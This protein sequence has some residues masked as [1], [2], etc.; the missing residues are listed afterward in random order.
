[1]QKRKVIAPWRKVIA[2]EKG[3]R[4]MQLKPTSDLRKPSRRDFALSAAAALACPSALYAHPFAGLPTSGTAT[5]TRFSF[6]LWALAKQLPFDRCLEVV[7]AAGYQGVELTGEFQ[8]WSPAETT[9]ILNHMHDLGLV[10][11]SMSG[12]RAGFAVPEETQAFL[13]QFAQHLRYAQQLSCP[14]VILLSGKRMAG[15]TPDVQRTTAIENL[16]RAGD[17]AAKASV[18]IVIEPIDLLENPS[19]YLSSV[20]QAF[21]L[22]RAV[23]TPSV[24]VLYDFYH[25]QR[26]YG[27]LLEK[28]ESGFDQIGLIHIAD[29]PGRHEPGSGEVDFGTIYRK[30]KLLGYKR[31]IAMEYYPTEGPASSLRRSREEAQAE[32]GIPRA[33]MKN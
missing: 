12:V 26:S 5:G 18:E 24:K 14:Q 21:D 4:N 28:L 27:N 19:I 16:K 17:M 10:V 9:R 20:T 25:E 7:S 29:V 15:L 33:V 30:L 31:W 2:T 3:V 11:D 22:T 1:M 8:T 23:G 13:T 32:L 6:M